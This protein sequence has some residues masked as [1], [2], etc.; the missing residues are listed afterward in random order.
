VLLRS[1]PDACAPLGF[2]DPQFRELLT[3]QNYGNEGQRQNARFN[4]PAMTPGYIDAVILEFAR[5]L[6]PSGYL[7]RWTDKF[8]LCEGRHLSIPAD[9]F[10]VVDLIAA[11]YARIGMGYRTRCRGD[12]LLVLQRPPIKAK[13]TWRDHG[14]PDRWIEKVDRKLHPHIKPIGLIK[15]LIAATTAPSELVIDPAA[16]SFVVLHAAA[17]LGREF[18][19]CDIAEISKFQ[20]VSRDPAGE[21]RDPA[22]AIQTGCN[23]EVVS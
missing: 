12:F 5:V 23:S 10:K 13:V 8:C 15:R 22:T 3:R 4:L 17:E 21:R 7:C 11:D 1:L 19:G 14:I 9:V 6:R 18:V 20:P 2:F 16:G